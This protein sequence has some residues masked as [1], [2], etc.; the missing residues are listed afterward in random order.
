MDIDNPGNY[1]CVKCWEAYNA[2]V[3][4]QQRTHL[5]KENR[6]L[7]TQNAALAITVANVLADMDKMKERMEKMN[8][9]A[10]RHWKETLYLEQKNDNLQFLLDYQVESLNVDRIRD[11]ENEVEM[12]ESLLNGRYDRIEEL[13]AQIEGLQALISAGNRDTTRWMTINHYFLILMRMGVL[14]TSK[15]SLMTR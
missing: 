11:L 15:M 8:D 13:E 5:V 10:E 14:N 7:S 2:D 12:Y 9:R 4:H 3:A 1:Y 6:F